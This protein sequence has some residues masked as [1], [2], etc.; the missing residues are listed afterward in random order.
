V[1][2][3]NNPTDRK[4][5]FK[6]KTTVPQRYSAEPAFGVIDPAQTVQ[7]AGENWAILRQK[8]ML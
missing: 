4:V 3:L 7:I 1:I 5:Y 8:I 2:K 6:I